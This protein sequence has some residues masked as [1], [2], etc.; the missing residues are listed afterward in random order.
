MK[1]RFTRNVIT[2]ALVA[3]TAAAAAEPSASPGLPGAEQARIAIEQDPA[4]VQALRAMEAAG[5]GAA[6]VRAGPY[7]W[8]VG[9]TVQRRRVV[10]APT[11]NEWSAQIERPIRIGGKAELDRQL[12][13]SAESAAR[14]QLAAARADSA[15]NLLD[16]WI[17]WLGARQSRQALDD[18]VR[19]AEDNLR[20]VTLR[21]KAG[22]ASRLELNVAEGDL[23]EARRQASAAGTAEA[24]AQAAL[25]V[26]YPTLGASSETDA[27]ALPDPVALEFDEAQWRERIVGEHPALAAASQALRKAELA[28]ERVRA[29]RVP[30]PTIGVFTSSE[31][32]RTERVVG[33]SLSIPLGGTYRD[34]AAREALKQV[35]VARAAVDRQRRDL[36]LQVATQVQEAIGN[37]ERWRL[38]EQSATA[39]RETARLTQKA[40]AN[41]EADVQAL[42]L[43]RR[44]AVDAA[45][46][47]QAARTDA[48][49]ARYR[50]MIDARMLWSQEER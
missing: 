46:A 29:D 47:A 15:R 30:D 1:R 9:G 5:H 8:T 12:G 20:T 16:G 7:E 35:E 17:D 23:A 37:L 6:M 34:Q 3:W 31:A 39:L 45:S 19:L 41:G 36:E 44:Q 27:A 2:A 32:S 25:R 42:L 49:R 21:R 22:D 14:A 28:A 4:V 24:R 10:G 38:A 40:Y 33:V 13:D 11:S 50:L 26:R 43:A 48:W 18:Q